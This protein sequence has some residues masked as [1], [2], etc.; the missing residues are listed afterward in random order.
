MTEL[1]V[2]IAVSAA[3]AIIMLASLVAAHEKHY[4]KR[5]LIHVDARLK[6]LETIIFEDRTT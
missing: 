2:I 4:A 1:R 5:R 6:A 3:L